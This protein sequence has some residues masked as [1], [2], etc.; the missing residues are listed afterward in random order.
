MGSILAKVCPWCF[1]NK[2]TTDHNHN[3]NH[4]YYQEIKETNLNELAEIENDY[5]LMTEKEEVKNVSDVKIKLSSFVLK[6]NNN[7]SELYELIKELGSGSYGKVFKVK[8]KIS[9]E[10][11]AM[12]IIKKEN[13]ATGISSFDI[14]RE[15]DILKRL[16]HPNIM[17]IFEFF[18]DD[19]NFYLVTEF[20]NQGDLVE[21]LTKMNPNM[22][23]EL[24]VKFLMY[25]TLSAVAYLHSK[26]VVHGD[27]KLENILLNS[28]DDSYVLNFNNLQRD[29][30]ELQ[31]ELNSSGLLKTQIDSKNFA[32]TNRFLTNISNYEVKLID[33]GCSKI[34]TKA[35]QRNLSGVIGTSY[36]CAPEVIENKYN[37]KCDEWTCGIIMYILLTGTPP[38]AGDSDEEIFSKIKSG[39]FSMNIPEFKNV[40]EEAKN[41]IAKLLI[42]NP[43]ERISAKD[44]LLHPFFFKDIDFRC[45]SNHSCEEFINSKFKISSPDMKFQ[46]AVLA[47]ISYNFADKEE[48][49]KLKKVFRTIDKNGDG[50]LDKEEFIQCFQLMGKTISEQE[51]DK[52][53]ESIDHDRNGYI[54]YEEFIRATL[55]KQNL[56][57]ESNLKS[58]FELFDA[59][60]NGEISCEEI[61]KIIFKDRIVPDGL[62]SEFL[63][64][65]NKKE[66]DSISFEEFC[67]IM[68]SINTD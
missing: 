43:K 6:R 10:E 28:S 26:K 11:R 35:G 41:L 65:I 8:H 42:Y 2:K 23:N 12:K 5:M 25:Q 45:I 63:A 7:P 38:F 50:H 44:A 32:K 67:N 4:N 62:M 60:G 54:E 40:S 64:Q 57:N 68:K 52:I 51:V 58:A 19:E 56:F 27:L 17:K 39:R 21:K 3:L 24:L 9:Q 33:F 53:I 1:K 31:K 20:C 16:D 61:K 36:Y 22:M 48:V 66:T 18:E 34:F 49:K 15:I 14:Q 13:I 47:Y 46:Q 37:E 30:I 55:D 59:D 29:A